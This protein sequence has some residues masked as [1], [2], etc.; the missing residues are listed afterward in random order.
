MVRMGEGS[1]D[2][3]RIS[4]RDLIIEAFARLSEGKPADRISVREI[5]REA[6]VSTVTF[7]NHFGSKAEMYTFLGRQMAEERIARLGEGYAW[8]DFLRDVLA[9]NTGAGETLSNL[10]SNTH[11]YE[12]YGSMLY[13]YTFEALEQR[14]ARGNPGHL[15]TR[16]RVALAAYTHAFLDSLDDWI[17]RGMPQDYDDLVEGL[18][19]AFPQTLVD[20]IPVR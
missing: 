19:D 20:Y 4:A 14:V 9:A 13:R 15:T 2:V 7:Y 5:C 16:E 10:T 8:R 18:C 6:G 17:A 3:E 1:G 11:G 12:E